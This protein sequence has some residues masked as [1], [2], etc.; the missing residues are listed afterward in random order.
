MT[1]GH[2]R[3]R[4]MT[5][6]NNDEIRRRQSKINTF[7]HQNPHFYG[8]LKSTFKNCSLKYFIH[9]SHTSRNG[10]SAYKENKIDPSTKLK[11]RLF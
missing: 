6:I 2:N 5:M 7:H 4:C 10:K 11:F 8:W 3:R 1:T 9:E